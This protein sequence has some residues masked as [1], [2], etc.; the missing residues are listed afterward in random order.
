MLSTSGVTNNLVRRVMEHRTRTARKHSTRY[1]NGK[2]VYWEV[3]A[4]PLAAIHRE[5]R[6]KKWQRSWKIELIE[7]R[8]PGWG[9]LAAAE[10]GLPVWR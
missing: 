7:R 2:L 6:L 9:D 3:I 1:R 10:L 8:N 5:K 4:G